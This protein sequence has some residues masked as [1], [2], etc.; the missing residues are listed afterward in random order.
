MQRRMTRIALATATLAVAI[1]AVAG[2]SSASPGASTQP[3][4]GSSSS[5]IPGP[6]VDITVGVAA[7]TGPIS[8]ILGIQ[9]GFFA[10]E[11]LNVTTTNVATGAAGI[12]QLINGQLQM[13]QAGLAGTITAAQ[14]GI[15]V[16]F[17]SGGV[18]DKTDAQ[19]SIYEVLT[20]PTSGIKSWKDLAGKKVA[21]NSLS[22]C[23]EFWLREAV[24]QDGGDQ[25]SMSLVQLPF[26]QQLSALQSGQVD[27]ASMQQPFA[28]QAEQAGMVS[29]GDSA[30]VANGRPDAGVSGDYFAA[31][32]WVD[33]NPGVLDRWR[34]ALQEASDYTNAHPDEARAALVTLSK[35]DPAVV[36]A[37]PL[38]N[39]TATIDTDAIQKEA[40][41]LVKYG[42]IPSAPGIDTLVAP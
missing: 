4:D 15:P 9:H 7:T 3:S 27:A 19:G 2:C 40:G 42:V 38:P 23:W 36:A 6:P 35:Q 37:A 18:T 31:T 21:L 5:A 26:A 20:S 34:K 41:W 32:K 12:S 30:A 39:Y 33:D 16:E 29:L 22:C 8:V 14:Q 17:V 28:A 25:S 10:Q 11:G 13:V 1:T 24:S